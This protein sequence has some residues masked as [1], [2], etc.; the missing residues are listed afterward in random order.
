MKDKD[1]W[2]LDDNKVEDS[3]GSREGTSEEVDGGMFQGL[4]Q[5]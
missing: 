4:G 3:M 1:R 5:V 2:D